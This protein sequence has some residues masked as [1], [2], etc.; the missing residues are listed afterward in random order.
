MDAV[1]RTL[2]LKENNIYFCTTHSIVYSAGCSGKDIMRSVEH[3]AGEVRMEGAGKPMR[4]RSNKSRLISNI[5]LELT[6]P[7]I[8]TAKR[9]R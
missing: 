7:K 3:G 1:T 8:T 5:V 2:Q 9:R 6:C 4:M